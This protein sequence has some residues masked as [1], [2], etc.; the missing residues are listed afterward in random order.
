MTNRTTQ[1]SGAIW[2][3]PKNVRFCRNCHTI[4]RP[5]PH[6]VMHVA[7]KKLPNVIFLGGWPASRV[8]VCRNLSRGDRGET[9]PHFFFIGVILMNGISN[10]RRVIFVTRTWAFFFKSLAESQQICLRFENAQVWMQPACEQCG[11]V[12]CVAFCLARSQVRFLVFC[13]VF[14]RNKTATCVW[15]GIK[16][17]AWCAFCR[18]FF[19]F[20]LFIYLFFLTYVL[21][22]RAGLRISA[23]YLGTLGCECGLSVTKAL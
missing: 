11:K 20:F 15:G 22:T 18:G 19:F 7:Q 4:N 21:E 10:V 2:M 9:A 16:K 23:C 8:V 12:A 1:I 14:R 3:A 5:K 6:R 13:R 17:W